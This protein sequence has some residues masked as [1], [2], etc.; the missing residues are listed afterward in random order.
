MTNDLNYKGIFIT[1]EGVEGAGKST[2]MDYI[3]ELLKQSGRKVVLTREPGGTQTGEQIRN[4]LFRFMPL[5][6]P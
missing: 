6:P 1:L 5:P 4:I 3:A 2:L